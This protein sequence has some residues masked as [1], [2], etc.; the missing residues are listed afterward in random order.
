M[1]GLAA[2]AVA[3]CA[4]RTNNAGEPSRPSSAT[5]DPTVREHIRAWEAGAA[6]NLL[7]FTG[8]GHRPVYLL[9][10]P[11]CDQFNRLYDAEGRYICAPTGGFAGSGDGKC[12][13]WVHAMLYRGA[14]RLPSSVG[15]QNR[16]V[17]VVVTGEDNPRP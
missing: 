9:Q 11:C 2:L 6:R 10:A 1:T 16:S 7:S 17:T 13:D 8:P 5:G 15:A 12:P 3:G 4:S 14:V